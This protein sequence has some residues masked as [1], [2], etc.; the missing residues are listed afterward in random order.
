[1]ENE[2]GKKAYRSGRAWATQ[3]VKHSLTLLVGIWYARNDQ[4]HGNDDGEG[5]LSH[6]IQEIHQRV[7]ETYADKRLYNRAMRAKLFDMTLD[8][9][10]QL[11]QRPFQLVKWIQTVE[12]TAQIVKPIYAHYHTTRPP[13]DLDMM[14]T[15]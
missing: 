6:K 13:Y 10:L 11:Q 5:T 7:R 14:A 2:Q 3:L 1:M 15:I 9:R 12:M 8:Q 4:F